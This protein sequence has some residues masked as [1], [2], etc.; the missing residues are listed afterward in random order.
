MSK[1]CPNVENDVLDQITDPFFRQVYID[2][3]SLAEIKHTQKAAPVL[4]ERAM[5]TEVDQA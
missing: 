2:A 4:A 3:L 5:I 1:E